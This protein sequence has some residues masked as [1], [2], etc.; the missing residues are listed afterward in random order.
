MN[1]K[2]KI[3]KSKISYTWD[4]NGALIVDIYSLI[5]SEEFRKQVEAACKLAEYQRKFKNEKC[6]MGNSNKSN[7]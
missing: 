7:K 3:N 6:D 1:N 4:R 2:S 5:H